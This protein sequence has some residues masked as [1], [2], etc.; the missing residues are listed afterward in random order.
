MSAIASAAAAQDVSFDAMTDGID[1]QWT[2]S[3]GAR[4]VRVLGARAGLFHLV[5]A[6]WI[7][8][9]RGTLWEVFESGHLQA[10]LLDDFSVSELAI[11]KPSEIVVA[12]AFLP[13][14]SPSVALVLQRRS[15]GLERVVLV[16]LEDGSTV[17][18]A[19]SRPIGFDLRAALDGSRLLVSH[20]LSTSALSF[21]PDGSGGPSLDAASPP[22][23]RAHWA[24]VDHDTWL[25]INR[26][27][28]ERGEVGGAGK[29]VRKGDFGVIETL[30]GA[31]GGSELAYIAR[32]GSSVALHVIDS[33]GVERFELPIDSRIEWPSGIDREGSFV[34]LVTEAC[35]K[36]DHAGRPSFSYTNDE[37]WLGFYRGQ[38]VARSARL[39]LLRDPDAPH[40]EPSAKPDA[41]G[42]TSL[43][44]SRD[45][46]RAITIE[47]DD[48]LRCYDTNDGTILQELVIDGTHCL[49]GMCEGDR[50]VA[51][52]RRDEA[53][54]SVSLWRPFDEC[55][56]LSEVF[57]LDESSA[58]R[59]LAVSSDGSRVAVASI[60]RE[61]L[62]V[63][64]RRSNDEP[65]V[66]LACTRPLA[67]R[68]VHDDRALIVREPLVQRRW[69]L[70]GNEPS[71]DERTEEKNA[72]DAL[73]VC[74]SAALTA[75]SEHEDTPA[76]SLSVERGRSQWEDGAMLRRRIHAL[77]VADGA[78]ITAVSLA[79]SITI[80]VLDAHGTEL[81]RAERRQSTADRVTSMAFSEDGRRLVVGTEGG[82]LIVIDLELRPR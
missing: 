56:A 40:A 77:A 10:T 48:R 28:V 69:S 1:P 45:G 30:F 43:A 55:A 61:E 82:Q 81:A 42:I 80:V 20:S 47:G 4:S 72:E 17:E 23:E 59:V 46:R 13:A 52:V 79:P 2:A 7:D 57:S 6:H 9:R 8:R 71:C 68:F 37:R 33:H 44:L 16:R 73:F 27:R 34:A 19:K 11:A 78:P 21:G 54:T 24:L 25:S 50:A 3:G 35:G 58:P 18:L 14:D 66:Q 60:G 15:A 53:D 65:R 12:A 62:Y 39:L 26:T 74:V 51:V 75:V 76:V 41:R 63:L 49:A 67:A 31:I 22:F 5:I 29:V 36:V 70:D 38:L 32:R 64:S